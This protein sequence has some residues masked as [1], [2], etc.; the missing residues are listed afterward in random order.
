[1]LPDIAIV[2]DNI[3]LIS[4]YLRHH[5]ERMEQK[6]TAPTRVLTKSIVIG[7][8]STV[9]LFFIDN[10][11]VVMRQRSDDFPYIKYALLTP[12]WESIRQYM[13]SMLPELAKIIAMPSSLVFVIFVGAL[14][15]CIVG[16]VIYYAK[17]QHVQ[18]VQSYD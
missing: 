2:V 6:N 13:G 10:V 16:L 4:I 1:M 9:I 14:Y 8:A 7:I 5:T 18:T 15:G 17:K 11:L 12:V 3:N